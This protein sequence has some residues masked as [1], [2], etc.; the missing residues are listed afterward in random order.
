MSEV[1]ILSYIATGHS[2]YDTASTASVSDTRGLAMDVG[3]SQVTSGAERAAQ[4]AIGLDVLQVRFD[5]LQGAT[6]VAGRYLF[7][8]LY[9]GFRQPLQYKDTGSPSAG[10]TYRN[11]VE[12]EYALYRWLILDVQGESTSLRSFL[13]ARHEY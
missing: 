1:E 7:P 8:D 13:R 5:A 6:L 12:V 2:P 10:V 3:L 4:Q 9:V 11:S